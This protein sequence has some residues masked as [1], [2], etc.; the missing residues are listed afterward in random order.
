MLK[1][2]WS[3]LGYEDVEEVIDASQNN[4]PQK[5]VKKNEQYDN[6]E[7]YSIKENSEMY[8][9]RQKDEKKLI[10]DFEDFFLSYK[11][12][13]LNENELK[14]IKKSMNMDNIL[15]NISKTLNESK[16]EEFMKILEIVKKEKNNNNNIELTGIISKEN[17]NNY[18]ENDYI[19]IFTYKNFDKFYESWKEYSYKNINLDEDELKIIFE[20]LL[21]LSYD[22]TENENKF[23]E[24]KRILEKVAKRKY[25]NGN[26]KLKNIMYLGT[27]FPE[28]YEKEYSKNIYKLFF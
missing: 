16:Y 9:F 13:L 7:E 21:N 8:Y 26:K 19:L 27:T 5:V 3:L 10:I 1:Y 18:F 2:F 23:L 6:F 12:E 17:E 4:I 15:F 24:I 14:L 22:T 25:D 28:V 11:D 20:R